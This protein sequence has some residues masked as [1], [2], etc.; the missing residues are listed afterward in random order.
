MQRIFFNFNV[1]RDVT[2]LR[3][4]YLEMVQVSFFEYVTLL[5]KSQHELPNNYLKCLNMVMP[6]QHSQLNCMNYKHAL[7]SLIEPKRS[8]GS[9]FVQVIA[10]NKH[11]ADE[12]Q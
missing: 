8:G 5:H 4:F 1:Q 10:E 6:H 11:T 12:G 7:W 2:Y 9:V 3:V